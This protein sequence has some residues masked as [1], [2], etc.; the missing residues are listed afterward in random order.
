MLLLQSIG[1]LIGLY[2]GCIDLLNLH[3]A[4]STHLPS[5]GHVHAS[6]EKGTVIEMELDLNEPAGR[7][8]FLI[9]LGSVVALPVLNVVTWIVAKF[10]TSLPSVT[11]FFGSI[12]AVGSILAVKTVSP[13]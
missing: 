9:R 8:V 7:R 3:T 6:D 2:I 11:I 13:I 5:P 10:V 4:L 12:A 1:T